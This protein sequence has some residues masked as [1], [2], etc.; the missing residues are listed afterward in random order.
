[1]Y[2]IEPF[3]DRL[4]CILSST[5][6]KDILKLDSKMLADIL[7]ENRVVLIRGYDT[8]LEIF[9][10]FSDQFGN[11]FL[12][13]YTPSTRPSLAADS[14]ITG[15]LVGNHRVNL[16]GEMYYF[17]VR[18]DILFLN[19]TLPAARDGETT[20]C[21][22]L[23]FYDELN[24]SLRKLFET[25][26]IK[27]QHTMTN[28]EVEQVYGWKNL[29]ETRAGLTNLGF[30]SIS[31]GETG[32]V[33]F[34]YLTSAILESR[35]NGRPAFLNSI[36]NM[37]NTIKKTNKTLVSFADGTEISDAI[38]RQIDEIGEKIALK[39]EWRANDILMIDNLSVLHGRCAFSGARSI[40]TRFAAGK[41]A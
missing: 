9:R 10:K 24:P 1:M 41:A 8:D 19:C 6:G 21:D 38:V 39:V 2:K 5:A 15:V 27:Y 7:L 28:E 14:T 23:R 35:L 33:K 36:V 16:H 26:Q 32:L 30:S 18:P 11:R 20:V 31:T 29:A 13:H 37:K 25:K 40:S 12:K 17:P 34:E 22:A 4:G 3:S